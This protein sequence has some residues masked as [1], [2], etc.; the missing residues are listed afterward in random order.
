MADA[1]LGK[2]IWIKYATII[3]KNLYDHKEVSEK[4]LR[5]M[6]EEFQAT[7]TEEMNASLTKK[8][9]VS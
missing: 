9:T 5:K 1:L 7:F 2:K 6:F 8:I 3:Y 4:A